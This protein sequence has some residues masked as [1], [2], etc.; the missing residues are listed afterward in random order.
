MPYS[1]RSVIVHQGPN[2]T[3]GHYTCDWVIGPGSYVTFDD[4]RLTEARVG[5][6]K[7]TKNTTPWGCCYVKIDKQTIPHRYNSQMFFRGSGDPFKLAKTKIV[8]QYR[9]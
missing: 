6:A 3:G 8:K 9:A 1:L 2:S 7:F 5:T 4:T